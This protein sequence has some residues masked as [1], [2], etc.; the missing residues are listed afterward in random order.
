M[1]LS[2]SISNSSESLSILNNQLCDSPGIPL[3]GLI[4]DKESDNNNTKDFPVSDFE[5][6]GSMFCFDS[7]NQEKKC[8]KKNDKIELKLENIFTEKVEDE[9][10]LAFQGQLNAD[11]EK[12]K[13]ETFEQINNDS[14]NHFSS[15][16]NEKDLV[17]EHLKKLDFDE[18][19]PK[20][21][22]N[23]RKNKQFDMFLKS[24]TTKTSVSQ[25]NSTTRFNFESM[26]QKNNSNSK[27]TFIQQKLNSNFC[28]YIFNQMRNNP[29][30]KIDQSSLAQAIN[31][32]NHV[33]LKKMS[34][35]STNIRDSFN[36]FLQTRKS[37]ELTSIGNIEEKGSL[38]STGLRRKDVIFA[39]IK[40][41]IKN[42]QKTQT[43]AFVN[44]ASL[45]NQTPEL[46]RKKEKI[47]G[48]IN[49]SLKT[50]SMKNIYTPQRTDKKK[51]PRTS[52]RKRDKMTL[53]D[54]EIYDNSTNL[55]LAK[56][57]FELFN[58]SN[59]NVLVE[60][61]MTLTPK[62]KI[63]S[64]PKSGL[65]KKQ[66]KIAKLTQNNS[67]NKN[68]KKCGCR[69]K[70]TK[71]TRLHCICFRERGYCGDH[72]SCTDCFN[73][74]EFSD[75]IKKIRDFTKEINPLAF[76]SKIEAIG[77]ENR[78]KIHNRG[79]SCRKNECRK[80]YCE[81]FKNGLS[82]SPLC[83]CENCKNE[84]VEIDVS[85]VKEIFKKCSRKKKKFVIFLNKEKPSIK[86]IQ[87]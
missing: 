81:C 32:E 16:E 52:I 86:K 42:K 55:K 18:E 1:K 29:Q 69:C 13:R 51:I 3:R 65:K 74:E 49:Q 23:K 44:L 45:L 26:N 9:S 34:E 82:C 87:I 63:H 54:N 31:R 11:E 10:M 40:T 61:N 8:I 70:K 14:S 60:G 43:F 59:D 53:F 46:A 20:E 27:N 58:E 25:Q 22:E 71:C 6:K 85:K 12:L 35:K 78:Q 41:P 38:K 2:L 84:K 36:K 24:A 64:R 15:N 30:N 47:F 72:C 67:S 48:Y 5:L 4:E 39:D 80:N 83:K 57:N 21:L 7:K 56:R 75:T 50:I 17:F 76:Q 37:N 77:N 68:S 79:C 73:R 33:N 66:S 19:E 28:Y 62:K